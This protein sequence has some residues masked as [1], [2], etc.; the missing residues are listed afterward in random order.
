M[1]CNYAATQQGDAVMGIGV[2][3]FFIAVGAVLTF[4]VNASISGVD[5][6]TVGVILMIVGGLGLFLDLVIFAPRR[7]STSVTSTGTGVPTAGGTVVQ[8]HDSY[9]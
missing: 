4:A 3:L 6:A 2:G 8:Q 5:I 9:V 1:R 7:R